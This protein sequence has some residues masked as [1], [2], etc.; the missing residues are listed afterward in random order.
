MAKQ[1]TFSL[2]KP[3]HTQWFSTTASPA[4]RHFKNTEFPV[5]R[6]LMLADTFKDTPAGKSCHRTQR[7]SLSLCFL[8]SIS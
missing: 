8:A 6:Y 2:P 5:L 3:I 7:L 4:V 1:G